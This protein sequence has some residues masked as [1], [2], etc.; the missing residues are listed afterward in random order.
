MRADPWPLIGRGRECAAVQRA[1]DTSPGL[2]LVI[3]GPAGVGRSRMAREAL[4]LAEERERPT[5]WAVATEAAAHVPLGA[6]AHLLPVLDVAADPLVLLQRAAAALSGEGNGPAP[7]LGVDDVHL[8]DPLSVTLLHHLAVS[9]AVTLVLTVRTHRYTPDPATALWKD[10][11]AGRLELRPL[12]ATDVDG[13]AGE[14]LD[15]HLATRTGER[16]WQLSQGSPLYLRELVEHGLRTGQLRSS[17]RLWRWE[18]AMEPSDRLSEIVLSHIGGLT[19]GEWRTL[20]VLAA[21]EPLDLHRAVELSSAEAV[22]SLERRGVLTVDLRDGVSEVRTAQPLYGAVIRQRTPGASLQIMRR[23][24]AE[25]LATHASREERLRRC[26]VL[27]DSGVLPR[28]TGLLV[29]AARR[30]SAALD[31]PLAERLAGAAVEAGAGGEAV[32]VLVESLLW[33]GR[34]HDSEQLAAQS[35]PSAG[36]DARADLAVSRALALT[37][38]LGRRAEAGAVLADAVGA[39]ASEPA[40][41]VL[42]AAGAVLSFLH[43]EPLTAVH[44]GTS[45]LDSGSCDGAAQP[46]AAAAV[47]AGLA[48]TGRTGQALATAS[49]GWASLQ[50]DHGAAAPALVRVLLAHAEL[51]ALHLGGR[52]HEL[53][54]RA[55]ELHRLNLATAEWAGDDVA[56]LHLGFAALAGG[57]AWSAVR[58]LEEAHAGLERRDPL[59]LR[60]WAAA[61]LAT[62]RTLLGDPTGAREVLAG[63]TTA[64]LPVLEPS[65]RLAEACVTAAEGRAAAARTA[66]LD[67]AALAAAQ[68]QAAVEGVLLHGALRLGATRVAER[69]RRL[70]EDLDAPLL[71]PFAAHAEAA[72]AGSGE[73][74][75]RVSTAFEHIG[76]AL[77]ASETAAEAA[78]AH[79][80]AGDRRAAA[81][82]AARALKLARAGGLADTPALDVLSPSVLTA[83]EDQVARLAARGLS[84]QSIAGRLVLSVRTVE[85]HLAHV[86]AKLGIAGRADLAEALHVA[87]HA[88]P[89]GPDEDTRLT[90]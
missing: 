9:G 55:G 40:R 35:A 24:L 86:Y 87:T 84:N 44:E 12:T 17:G 32:P 48:V 10:G 18:G 19:D 5:R 70:A 53:Q 28:D 57:R 73:A 75:D 52:L 20:E 67:A 15:G 25:D 76:E 89:G 34:S 29:E 41:S 80:R 64:G 4:R 13:I 54:E 58:W 74:L 26:G 3:S 78:A 45:L 77:A 81:G 42:V 62:A 60:P 14:V 43:G 11:L 65:C 23:R 21:A 22:T 71:A 88:R 69:L 46:L 31:H 30:A 72:A 61:L 16:L 50:S 79:E 27:V 83:R 56:C 2:N 82:A 90:G 1:L 6:V 8:L 7:V 63:V 51:T 68:G 49:A 37:C 39:V 59:G 38:G 47:A 85:A 33:Q 66:A 36:E